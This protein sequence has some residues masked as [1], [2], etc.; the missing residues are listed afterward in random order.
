MRKIFITIAILLFVNTIV[1]CFTFSALLYTYITYSTHIHTVAYIVYNLANDIQYQ[2]KQIDKKQLVTTV[3]NTYNFTQK[4]NLL[5]H[6]EADTIVTQLK[7]IIQIHAYKIIPTIITLVN[8]LKD[9]ITRIATIA[10]QPNINKIQRFIDNMAN[11]SW[12]FQTYT[13]ILNKSIMNTV[14]STVERVEKVK[15]KKWL[16]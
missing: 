9:P 3:Q 2:Y 12:Q 8:K 1:V 13:L 14:D 5:V 6:Q 11:V 4:A 16:N 7:H 15:L 10:N